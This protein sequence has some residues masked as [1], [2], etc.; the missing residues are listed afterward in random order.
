MRRYAIASA[1]VGIGVAVTASACGGTNYANDAQAWT[2]RPD[3]NGGTLS[4]R[5][6]SVI[7]VEVVDA[8]GHCYAL[9]SVD[10][11]EFTTST[12]EAGKPDPVTIKLAVSIDGREDCSLARP[13]P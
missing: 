11:V 1:L 3:L 13:Q 8:A 6:G 9:D 5:D 4:F 10:P 2:A 7:H 12:D